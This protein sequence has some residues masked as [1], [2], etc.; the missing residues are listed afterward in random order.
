VTRH[1]ITNVMQ[2]S[3]AT[4]EH[5]EALVDSIVAQIDW[6]SLVPGLAPEETRALATF[7][8][9]R[10]E[11]DLIVGT[12]QLVAEIAAL[13]GFDAMKAR[14]GLR[15]YAT[16]D[17]VQFGR[18]EDLVVLDPER[19]DA[20]AAKLV[21][22]ASERQGRLTRAALL[23]ARALRDVPAP[24]QEQ[25]LGY[26]GSEGQCIALPPDEW[27][28]PALAHQP[29]WHI[30][31]FTHQILESAPFDASI[32]F[33]GA[34]DILFARLV[35]ALGDLKGEPA[36]FSNSAALWV[37]GTGRA[38]TALLVRLIGSHTGTVIRIRAGGESG[39]AAGAECADLVRDLLGIYRYQEDLAVT[40]I[41]D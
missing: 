24:A 7:L 34:G 33:V 23:Q 38:S 2:A 27:L 13:P 14:A 16:Q 6:P 32:R 12:A 35:V 39:Q 4:G 17:L 29:R 28:F 9:Q 26:L 5:V 19:C 22:V 15:T 37:T 25:V 31:D 1:A 30:D 8:H 11:R 21:R 20:I 41:P 18:S 36:Q 10:R 40:S 3:A